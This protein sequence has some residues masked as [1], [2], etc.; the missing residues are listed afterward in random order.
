ME[1]LGVI[2]RVESSTD[3]VVVAK[4]KATPSSGEGVASATHKVRICVDA[5]EREREA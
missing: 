1:G 4:P 2:R 3:M 5:V